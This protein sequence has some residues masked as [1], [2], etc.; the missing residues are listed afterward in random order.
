MPASA[1]AALESGSSA[2]TREQHLA[3]D[4]GM[5][6]QRLLEHRV[7]EHHD[8]EVEVPFQEQLSPARFAHEPAYVLAADDDRAAFIEDRQHI[9]QAA[10][11]A[12][13]FPLSRISAACMA[14]MRAFVRGKDEPGQAR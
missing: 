8:A 7:A 4:A 5:R 12:A 14:L 13:H 11:L 1:C 9:A 2:G 10:A 3:S 6:R